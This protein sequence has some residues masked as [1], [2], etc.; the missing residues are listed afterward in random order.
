L[1]LTG[2]SGSM[3]GVQEKVGSDTSRVR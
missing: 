3:P 2:K 1:D